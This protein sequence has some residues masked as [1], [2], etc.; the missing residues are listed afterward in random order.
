MKSASL[1]VMA[2]VLSSLVVAACSNGGGGGIPSA[3]P[4]GPANFNLCTNVATDDL[5]QSYNASQSNF[6]VRGS[7]GTETCTADVNDNG[8]VTHVQKNGYPSV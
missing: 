1:P 2:M 7:G 4:G 6:R 3:T 5:I 8:K